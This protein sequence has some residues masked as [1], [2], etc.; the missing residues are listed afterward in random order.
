M[1][2]PRSIINA[3]DF[4]TGADLWDYVKKFDDDAVGSWERYMEFH[5]W[6]KAAMDVFMQVRGLG[7]GKGGRGGCHSPIRSHHEQPPAPPCA[8]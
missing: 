3:A 2:G 8:G 6:R 5:A 4:K 1:P 7:C